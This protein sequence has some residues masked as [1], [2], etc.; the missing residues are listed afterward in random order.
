M[1]WIGFSIAFV[2][3]FASH[4]IPARPLVKAWLVQRLLDPRLGLG[5]MAELVAL[6][7]HAARLPDR[8]V[9]LRQTQPLLLWRQY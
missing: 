5:T 7:C 4:S 2:M 6:G 3:F 8:D 9:V 1:E